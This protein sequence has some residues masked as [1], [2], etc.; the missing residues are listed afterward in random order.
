MVVRE[1]DVNCATGSGARAR[2]ETSSGMRNWS[3][4]TACST[5]RRAVELVVMSAVVQG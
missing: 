4:R 5:P 3:A 1:G 2:I